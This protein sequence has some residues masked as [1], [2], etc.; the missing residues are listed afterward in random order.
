MLPPTSDEPILVFASK[1][2]VPQFCSLTGSNT[3]ETIVF[4]N[5]KEAPD[6]PPD[7][8]LKKF[9]GA[10]RDTNWQYDCANAFLDRAITA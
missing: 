2:Y 6:V 1:S 9:E 8:V 4:Y 7:W 3:G 5:A 10:K